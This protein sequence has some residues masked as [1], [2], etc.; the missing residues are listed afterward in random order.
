MIRDREEDRRRAVENLDRRY[1]DFPW[2]GIM[3]AWS[4]AESD[5]PDFEHAFA[6][7]E[8]EIVRIEAR[9]D[10]DLDELLWRAR[11]SLARMHQ[12]ALDHR[13]AV[14]LLQPLYAQ[15]R[16]DE[17]EEIPAAFSLVRSLNRTGRHDEAVTVLRGIEERY[18][19]Y[20]NLE[21]LRVETGLL[22]GPTGLVYEAALPAR[23]LARDGKTKEAEAAFRA[24]LQRYPDHP[25]IHFRMAEMYFDEKQYSRAEAHLLKAVEGD[26]AMP[27]YVVP[28]GRMQLGQI[29]DVTDRRREAKANYRRAI[30]AAKDFA[31]LREM[32]KG[33][34]KEPYV[35]PEG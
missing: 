33:Y 12:S 14:E 29:C 13:T 35:P 10:E 18:P 11:I 20:E 7:H 27:T 2:A 8:E 31:G 25:E 23:V 1:P 17:D 26:P 30:D 6:L 32:S 24:L 4:Y 19:D 21:V 28:Y 22:D 3:L 5:P 9:E 34:L 16:G 15:A